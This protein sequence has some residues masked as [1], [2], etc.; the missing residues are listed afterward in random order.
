MYYY[1]RLKKQR[2]GGYIVDFPMLRGCMTEGDTLEAALKNAKEALDGWLAANCD[3]D[4]DVP[5]SNRRMGRNIHPVQ[6]DARIEF[7]IRLR[8]L[9]RSRGLTQAEVARRLG[10]SQQ[11]YAR[12]EMPDQCNPSLSTIQKLSTA[13]GA[14]IRI[15]VAA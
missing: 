4:L 10:T 8:R 3:L 15:E 12:L 13:L 2:E 11:A 9:R 5:R 7:A 1:A 6:V 14:E